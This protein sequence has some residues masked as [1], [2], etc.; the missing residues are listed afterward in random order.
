[1]SAPISGTL[2]FLDMT[3]LISGNFLCTAP[4]IAEKKDVYRIRIKRS[5]II[6]SHIGDGGVLVG[7]CL[8]PRIFDKEG[9]IVG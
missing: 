1:M 7:L 4:G 2:A 3:C 6:T 9:A 5:G 8:F